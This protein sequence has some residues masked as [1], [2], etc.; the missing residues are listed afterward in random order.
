MIYPT[1]YCTNERLELF[2][3][4]KVDLIFLLSWE[5]YVLFAEAFCDFTFESLG[6][7][8]VFN[9]IDEKASLIAW[10]NFAKLLSMRSLWHDNC[11]AMSLDDV[12]TVAGDLLWAPRIHKNYEILNE[13]SV[14]RSYRHLFSNCQISFFEI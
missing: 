1:S 2:V 7:K 13:W 14:W 11:W 10:F 12:A 3:E 5:I 8:S 9:L 6:R 4:V